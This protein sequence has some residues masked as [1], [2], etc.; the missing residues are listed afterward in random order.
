[1]ERLFIGQIQVELVF[2][3]LYIQTFPGLWN[4]GSSAELGNIGA[5]QLDGS[6]YTELKVG[7]GLAA[8]ALTDDL[9]LWMT[10]SGN[11]SLQLHSYDCLITQLRASK[12]LICPSLTCGW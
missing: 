7:D 4:D 1:M 6:D 11:G 5:V 9:L 8:V 2:K 10:V 3:L 12:F